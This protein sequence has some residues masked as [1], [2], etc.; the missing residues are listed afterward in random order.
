MMRFFNTGLIVAAGLALAAVAPAAAQAQAQAARFGYINSQKILA[1]APGAIEAQKRFEQEMTGFRGEIQPMEKQLETL[2]KGLETQAQ[3]LQKLV[4]DYEKQQATLTAE[5]R[6]TREQEILQKQEAFESQRGEYQQ[7]LLTYQQK[8]QELEQKA[9]QRQQ[10][11]VEPI[12]KQISQVI[13]ELRK[14]GNYAM[15][16]DVAGGTML[17]AAD[18]ALDLSDQVL[19]RLKT[20]PATGQP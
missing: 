4:Q 13:E 3:A 5:G 11:L 16:F 17:V 2:Q 15:I 9:Q 14:E 19:A 10:A 7:Q 1:E 6:Q 18:P 12:M 8:R 20:A